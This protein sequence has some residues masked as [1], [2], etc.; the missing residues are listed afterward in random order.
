MPQPRHHLAF[1]LWP[2]SPEA[3]ARANLR[4]RLHE[5]RQVLP[6]AGQCLQTDSLA[7]GWRAD[8]P[9]WLDVAAF[10]QGVAGA[11]TPA[12][13]AGT[14]ALYGGDLL[15]RCYD[16]WIVAERERLRQIYGVALERLVARMER[17]WQRAGVFGRLRQAGALDPRPARPRRPSG[18]PQV[19]LITRQRASRSVL[20][21][22]GK[23]RGNPVGVPS[24]C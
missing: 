19:A 12:A 9:L 15:P 6:D 13:L 5:L 7:V 2:E 24:S 1:V 4:Q 8:A 14:A 16:E 20:G 3:N 23:E 18:P 17:A 11:T 10:E 21:R 22:D